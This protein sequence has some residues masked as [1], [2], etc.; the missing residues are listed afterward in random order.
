MESGNTD[1]DKNDVDA[2]N[3]DNADENGNDANVKVWQEVLS[4]QEGDGEPERTPHLANH[5][6]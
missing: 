5:T 1:K 4:S 2:E 6:F 3:E